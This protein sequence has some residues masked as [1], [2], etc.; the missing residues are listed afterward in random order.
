[1]PTDE[2][3][4]DIELFLKEYGE[5][6]AKHKVDFANYPMFQPNKEGKWEIVVQA[7]AISIKDR[8]VISP[9]VPQ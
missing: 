3:K 4:E 6:V 7:Q 8:P 1:M 9:F 2:H 5:L